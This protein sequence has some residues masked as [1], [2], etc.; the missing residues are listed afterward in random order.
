ME[1]LGQ[2][3]PR[4]FGPLFYP[5]PSFSFYCFLL[6]SPPKSKLALAPY[7]VFCREGFRRKQPTPRFTHFISAKTPTTVYRKT[8]RPTQSTQRQVTTG[9]KKWRTVPENR[10]RE[11]GISPRGREGI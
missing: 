10:P 1:R 9:W 4:R 2:V 8:S 3:F 6:A 7:V 11:P 5:P